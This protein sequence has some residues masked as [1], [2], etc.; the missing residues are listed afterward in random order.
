MGKYRNCGEMFNSDIKV[1]RESAATISKNK[2][3]GKDSIYGEIQKQRGT[4][5]Q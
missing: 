1:I 3:I 2:S 5:Q 4:V